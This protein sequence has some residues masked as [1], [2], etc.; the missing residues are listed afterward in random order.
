MP[1]RARRA[2]GGFSLIELL[3]TVLV[4]SI[5]LS[6]GVPAFRSFMQND[7]QW[8]GTNTLVLG[9]N[10]ARSEAIKND[11]TAG[12]QV[13]SSSNGTVCTPTPWNQG[14]IVLGV[15][16][17]NPRGPLKPLQVVGALPAGTTLTE[18]NNN[19]IITFMSNGTLL[20]QNP[21]ARV[22]F[23]MCD[24]RG[25]ASAR[26]LEVTPMGRVVASPVVGQDLNGVPLACP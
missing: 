6:L 9:L 17:A 20:L 24:A 7:Q 5:L 3:V 22:A 15:D 8:A 25:A 2:V 18:A 16:P 12:A 13:C 19:L 11:L 14:W 1:A 10:S 26:Y 4:L 21:A 23:T